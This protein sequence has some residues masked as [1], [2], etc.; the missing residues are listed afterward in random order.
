LGSRFAVHN[1]DMGDSE[2]LRTGG[3]AGRVWYS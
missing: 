2:P 3:R 1:S